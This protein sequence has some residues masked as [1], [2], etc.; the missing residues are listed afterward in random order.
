M[1]IK[2]IGIKEYDFTPEGSN[3]AIVG[4]RIVGI[5][6][7]ND[8]PEEGFRGNDVFRESISHTSAFTAEIG[9]EYDVGYQMTKVKD[10]ISGQVYN[11]AKPS[12]LIPV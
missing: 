4:A 1:R 3:R 8:T 2:V 10:K 9:K 12:M 6:T 11:V 7:K 5:I